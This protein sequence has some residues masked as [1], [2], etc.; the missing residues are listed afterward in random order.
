ML[1]TVKNGVDAATAY[2]LDQKIRQAYS[3][4][5][6]YYEDGDRIYFI[7]FSRGAFSARVL[8]G[9]IEL[10]GL[11]YPGLEEIVPT[12]WNIYKTWE[13]TRK[14]AGGEPNSGTQMTLA[15]EVSGG[16]SLLYFC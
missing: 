2:S 7:G 15:D 16:N 4:L 12:A 11:L 10:I 8:A 5:M 6:R 14:D 1:E 9:M 13:Y 3:F